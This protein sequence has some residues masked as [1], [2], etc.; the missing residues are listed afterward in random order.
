MKFFCKKFEKYYGLSVANQQK[1]E[2]RVRRIVKSYKKAKEN[3]KFLLTI[4][5]NYSKVKKEEINKTLNYFNKTF[6][7]KRK[8]KEEKS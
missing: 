2:Y 1:V 5:Q 3:L 6:A 8:M 7:Q 4:S